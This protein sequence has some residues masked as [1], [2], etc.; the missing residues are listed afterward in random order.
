MQS[1]DDI[2]R[3]CQITRRGCVRKERKRGRTERDMRVS[4]EIDDDV[5]DQGRG[6]IILYEPHQ[7]VTAVGKEAE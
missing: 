4:D 3:G 2:G 5:Y 6:L 7:G 1:K